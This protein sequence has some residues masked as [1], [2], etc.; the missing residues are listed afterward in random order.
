MQWQ[1]LKQKE[2]PE[3]KKLAVRGYMTYGIYKRVKNN[4]RQ[5]KCINEGV[6]L[7]II[8]TLGNIFFHNP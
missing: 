5:R 1:N 2:T 7:N 6:Q 4:T 8:R 3:F